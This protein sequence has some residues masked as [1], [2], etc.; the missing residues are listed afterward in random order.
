VS[1]QP[2]TGLDRFLSRAASVLVVRD[3][4]VPA[5]SVARLGRFA[6][7]ATH[8]VLSAE[9]PA[10]IDGDDEDAA[11]EPPDAVVVVLRD[12]VALRRAAGAAQRLP[13]SR[14]VVCVLEEL[15]GQPPVP[16][17]APS[18]PRLVSL[19][20][21]PGPD[22]GVV[23]TA[24]LAAPIAAGVVLAEL[25]R[26]TTVGHLMSPGWPVL[27]AR[28]G[29]SRLW[30]PGDALSVVGSDE[31]IH[32]VS[33]DYPPDVLLLGTP[34]PPATEASR[35]PHRVLGRAQTEVV[36][37]AA[38]S[39]ADYE[40][41]PL[42]TALA[43][44]QGAGP[45]GLGPVDE[46]LV[47]PS[48]F[49]RRPTLPVGVLRPVPRH[50][51]LLRVEGGPDVVVDTGQGVGDATVARLR[52]KTGLH[53]TWEGGEGPH[54]YARTVAG[55]AMAGVPLTA[56]F[57][58]PWARAL[59][60]P[61]VATLLEAKPDLEDVLDREV[62]SIRLRRAALAAHGALP[63][64]RRL[65]SPT[66]DAS[67][68]PRV[69]V[70]LATRRPDHVPHAL[71]QVVRQRGAEV[72]L[73]LAT[74]GF[75]ADTS[76]VRALTGPS[77]VDVQTFAAPAEESFGRVLNAA[78]RRATGDVLLKMDDD[79]WYGPDFVR[80]LLLARDYSGA[81][82]VGC[83]PEFMYVEPLFVTVRR[84]DATEQ[85]RPVVAGGTMMVSREAFGAVGG[86]RD[87]RKYVD[88]N[89]FRA[90]RAAG[91]TIYRTHG[92]NYM[93][94]RQAS[95]HTWEPGLGYFVSRARSWQ[96]WRGFRPSP[97]LEL[98]PHDRP[99]RTSREE[100]PT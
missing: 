88:A 57:V 22:G 92:L 19:A 25:A 55:L 38:M 9:V 74:H 76:V 1:P 28:V 59:L 93:L 69:S 10:A 12:R 97:L 75:E 21:D 40:R 70:L 51:H 66:G 82:V 99:G 53:L 91:G 52:W 54:A 63:W 96:Q 90:V 98:D 17:P 95:G 72:E 27:G 71:R 11:P 94:R 87:T 100:S 79:D 36:L 37:G 23:V 7:R 34:G 56:D 31:A 89:L 64:R 43:R 47:N 73:V 46:K 8:R 3:A 78:A 24:E 35:A 62:H 49:I 14:R 29:E 86:F 65:A 81:D 84:R 80:D 20:V 42:H 44:L 5:G 61:V 26:R 83:P 50:R 39:W 45:A 2:A 13:A 33:G 85:Y 6:S 68:G 48:G 18:W 32:D 67:G 41:L 4:G 30:P 77:A 16:V 60:D 15:G 58:P